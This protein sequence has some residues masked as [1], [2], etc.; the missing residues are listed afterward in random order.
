MAKSKEQKILEKQIRT[1]QRTARAEGL[2]SGAHMV[3]GFRILD[4]QSEELLREILKQY[5]GNE[6][7]YI[8]FNSTVLP[9]Y[10]QDQCP[11]IYEALQ[12]YGL[13]SDVTSYFR[14]AM[15]TLTDS[16]KNYFIDKESVENRTTENIGER[17]P[18][19]TGKRHYDVFLSHANADKLDYVD[20]LYRSIQMLGIDIFYDSR[21]LSWGDDWKDVILKG[22]ETAEFAI[23]VISNN[24]FGRTWTEKELVKFL[25]RQNESGQKTILPLLYG[26]TIDEL[27]EHY[28][29]LADIQC[30]SADQY[31]KDQI[32]ILLAREL[33]KRYKTNGNS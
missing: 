14:G 20:N 4:P 21:V 22:T 31:S 16:G 6:N 29:E 17:A 24:Y 23:V 32:A 1:Q 5:N 8:N 9:R 26:I 13:V 19:M 25:G 12:M 33:I 18:S 7:N 10:L 28:P 2:V 27:R 30:I 11:V 3:D 15:I